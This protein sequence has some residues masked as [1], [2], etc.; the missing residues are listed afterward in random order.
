MLQKLG[1]YLLSSNTHAST[2]ALILAALSF[3]G[4]PT[5]F[6]AL[7]ILG[8][9]ALVKGPRA[10]LIVLAWAILPAL[11]MLY[12]HQWAFLDGI[13][14]LRS[15]LVLALALLLR[16][17]NS[18]HL[19]L[20]VSVGIGLLI[21]FGFH[22]FVPDVAHW[23][24]ESLKTYLANMDLHQALNMT[25][26]QVQGLLSQA[27][28]YM[29]GLLVT[30]TLIGVFLLLIMARWWQKLVQYSERSLGQEFSAIRMMPWDAGVILVAVI[31][32]LLAQNLAL[33]CLPILLFPFVVT[34]LSVVHYGAN[35]K[36]SESLLG[37][38]NLTKTLKVILLILYVGLI[39]V[40]WVLVGILALVGLIDSG[41]NIRQYVFDRKRV[42]A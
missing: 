23:W 31:G 30:G 29:T 11:C 41:F 3:W 19:V 25:Q 8:L 1:N 33:D 5:A 20:E 35:R 27:L 37:G 14:V 40:P 12:L 15:I 42:K 22:L 24:A 21:V 28:P 9:V 7:I 13:A 4:I 18:W 34:G 10:G 6:L 32:C 38:M 16:S 2:V 39:F 26:E 36:K 17:K